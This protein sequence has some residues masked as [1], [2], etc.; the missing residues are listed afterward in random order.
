MKATSVPMS[1][2]ADVPA[3]LGDHRVRRGAA[4]A[5]FAERVRGRRLE[6]GL[7][8]AAV[9]LAAGIAHDTLVNVERGHHEP[10]AYTLA[11]L[12]TALDSTMDALWNRAI[13]RSAQ[14]DKNE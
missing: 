6:L 8:R 13:D 7:T 4:I 5:T 2:V 1:R 14:N 9:A 12:A 10:R 11:A 3:T